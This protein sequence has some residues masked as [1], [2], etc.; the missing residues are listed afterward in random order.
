MVRTKASLTQS[1]RPTESVVTTMLSVACRTCACTPS[2]A[3][4]ATSSAAAALCSL[5]A[6]RVANPA[7]AMNSKKNADVTLNATINLL[8]WDTR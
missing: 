6:R 2:S 1:I 7:T 5:L 4:T 8:V 3:L